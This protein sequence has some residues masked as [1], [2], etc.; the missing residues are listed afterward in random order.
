M[1][2]KD[3]LISHLMFNFLVF[4]KNIVVGVFENVKIL[5]VLRYKNEKLFCEACIWEIF[6]FQK[7]KTEKE[8]EQTH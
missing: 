4:F 2:V 3:E 5:V 6:I 1:I 8:I 7:I